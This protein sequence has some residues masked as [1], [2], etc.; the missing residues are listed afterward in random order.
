[1]SEL[2]RPIKEAVRFSDFFLELLTKDLP[3]ELAVRRSRGTEGASIS[4]VVGH[5]CQARVEMM[6]LLRKE[7]EDPFVEQFE[8][9]VPATDGSGYPDID[10]LRASWQQMSDQLR[11]VLDSVTDEQLTSALPEAGTPHEEKNVLGILVY[12]MWHEVYH[13]GQIG[14]MRSSLGLKPTIDL[15]I[16]YWEAE[17]QS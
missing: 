13:M 3:N 16:E 6:K 12:I 7:I 5:L 10:E 14:T 8:R 11:D 2:I 15:A 9:T 4:W 1:M 17:G